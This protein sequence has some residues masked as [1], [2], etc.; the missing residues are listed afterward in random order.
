[1]MCYFENIKKKFHSPPHTHT[2]VYIHRENKAIG[3]MLATVESKW[4][5][6][7]FTVLFFQCC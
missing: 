6:L 3:K 2:Y 5:K 7:V 4:V 1:M